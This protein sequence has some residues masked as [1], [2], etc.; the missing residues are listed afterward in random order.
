VARRGAHR[1]RFTHHGA[2]GVDDRRR[3]PNIKNDKGARPVEP[4]CTDPIKDRC[5]ARLTVRRDRPRVRCGRVLC[6]VFER[7][8]L[9]IVHANDVRRHREEAI[10]VRRNLTFHADAQPL[11]AKALNET[12]ERPDGRGSS[13][14][15]FRRGRTG[16][17]VV[18]TG[19]RGE[20]RRKDEQ[21]D[22]ECSAQVSPP[23]RRALYIEVFSGLEFRE[24]ED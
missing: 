3:T 24:V 14:H 20:N 9:R 22:Q 21:H 16:R 2:K 15:C 4:G 18:S 11:F 7:V 12:I 17:V 6:R 19:N 5:A 13:G 1:K 8:H 23:D 10:Q